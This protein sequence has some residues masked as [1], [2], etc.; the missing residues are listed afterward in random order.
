MHSDGKSAITPL[1]TQEIVI[2]REFT[3]V[4]EIMFLCKRNRASI[5]RNNGGMTAVRYTY[6]ILNYP[7]GDSS[8]V[9]DMIILQKHVDRG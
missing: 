7:G 2:P 6:R 3:G 1:D 9:A 5:L 4:Y 8:V